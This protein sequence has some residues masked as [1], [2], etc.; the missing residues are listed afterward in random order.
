MGRLLTMGSWWENT[1]TPL[2][3]QSGLRRTSAFIQPSYLPCPVKRADHAQRTAVQ[4]V[5]ADH[6]RQYDLAVEQ[7][8]EKVQLSA[9]LEFLIG[10]LIH[11][12]LSTC[13]DYCHKCFRKNPKRVAPFAA[14][15]PRPIQRGRRNRPAIPA[16]LLCQMCHHR[17]PGGTL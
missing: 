9:S 13:S 8:L 7:Y 11:D 3:G 16:S 4:Y 5:G 1:L 6:R 10:F 12:G 2:A 14:R 15:L 17:T